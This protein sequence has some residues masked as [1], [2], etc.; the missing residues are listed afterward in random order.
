MDK[1]GAYHHGDLK[2]GLVASAREILEEE[3]LAALGLRAVARR[4]G[5]SAAAP[6]HHFADKVALLNEVAA[7]GFADLAAMQ[8]AKMDEEK[9][10]EKRLAILGV[11]YVRFACE[12]PALFRLMFG[13]GAI[14]GEVSENLKREAD[15]SFM[16]LQ[17]AC[18]AVLSQS[19]RAVP[20]PLMIL[21]AWSLVHGLSHLMID[22][23]T[24]PLGRAVLGGNPE[25]DLTVEEA[26]A[27]AAQ[28]T[29]L[30]LV[31]FAGNN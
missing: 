10:P 28:V 12:H 4:A 22:G 21:S 30:F 17:E 29:D 24:K 6:Y 31:Q 18:V 9:R 14:D 13:L 1:K 19:K 25:A 26:E 27:V 11:C 7:S 3:G 8:R 2:A 20:P 23:K 16:L 15:G 5:V